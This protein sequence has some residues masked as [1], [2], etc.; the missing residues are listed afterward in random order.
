MVY[1]TEKSLQEHGDKIDAATKSNIEA[2]VENTKKAIEGEDAQ[3]IQTSVQE[4]QQAAHKLAEVVYQQAA[5]P[6]PQHGEGPTDAGAGQAADQGAEDVV[7]ADY[8]E[9]KDQ[10]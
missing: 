8:T 9:V 4:L 5:G 2:A 6:G 7:D 3:A 10:K 1:Q